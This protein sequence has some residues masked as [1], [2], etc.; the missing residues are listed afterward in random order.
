[1]QSEMAA[2]FMSLKNYLIFFL[3]FNNFSIHRNIYCYKVTI[4]IEDY[5]FIQ[6]QT[7]QN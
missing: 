3:I 5:D 1:M 4:N 7:I 2:F 6:I